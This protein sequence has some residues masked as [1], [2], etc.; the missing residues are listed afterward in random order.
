MVPFQCVTAARPAS[1]LL[2]EEAPFQSPSA[3]EGCGTPSG[4]GSYFFGLL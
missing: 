2:L 3:S 1:L 4:Y